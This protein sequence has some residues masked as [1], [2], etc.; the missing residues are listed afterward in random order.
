MSQEFIKST[1]KYKTEFQLIKKKGARDL[2]E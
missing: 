1:K 2:L